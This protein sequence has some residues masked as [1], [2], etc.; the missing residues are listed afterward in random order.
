[1]TEQYTWTDNPTLSGVALCNTDVL[2]EC[3]MHLKYDKSGGSGLELCDIGTALYIDETIGLRRRLNGS[4]MD[5]TSNYQAFLA[6]L[7]EIKTTNPDYFTDEDTWQ[8]EATL[9]VDG[10]VYKFVLNYDSTGTNVVSVRLPKYPDY[11]EVTS[12]N[13]PVVGNGKTLG[14][15]TGSKNFGIME[16]ANQAVNNVFANRGA[17]NV[18][19]GKF[20]PTGWD[21]EIDQAL[22][23]TTDPTKSG[24]QT[25]GGITK[26]KLIYFIQVAT[27]QETENNIVDDIELNNPF[28]FGMSQYYKGEMNNISWLKSNGGFHPK[29]TYPSF[30]DWVYQQLNA[31]QFDPSKITVV[32]N[33]IITDDGIASGLSKEN[34]IKMYCPVEN[35]KHLKIKTTFKYFKKEGATLQPLFWL[36]PN[37]DINGRIMYLS[38]KPNGDLSTALRDKGYVSGSIERFIDGKTYTLEYE[39]DMVTYFKIYIDGVLVISQQTG[40]NIANITNKLNYIVLPAG[41]D[42]NNPTI[43][44]YDLK[45]FSITVDGEEVYSPTKRLDGF[46][47]NTENYDDYDIVINPTDETFR[48]ALKNGM[49]GMFASGVKG[50]GKALVVTDGNGNERNLFQSGNDYIFTNDN[51]AGNLPHVTASYNGNQTTSYALGTNVGLTTDSSKS[52]IVVDTTVPSGHNLYYYVGETVQNANLIDAGRIGEELGNKVSISNTQWATNAC[53]PDYTAGIALTSATLQGFVAPQIGIITGAINWNSST[54]Y[55]KVNGYDVLGGYTESSSAYIRLAKG[56]KLSYD[57]GVVEA[58]IT[59]LYFYPLKGANNV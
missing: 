17:F 43:I 36:Y 38:I 29:A 4:I 45:A 24:I 30:Y 37:A 59:R 3:L 1:M 31:K 16:T 42:T 53:T 22:G 39:T 19:V 55:L 27:G 46:K 6:R 5:I 2:N 51:V 28:A 52:G 12:N 25:S 13:I 9:N 15:T 8:S 49:E 48:L 56:D 41:L 26:L 7:L 18:P 44:E 32:G 23:V 14:F 40:L 11:V 34:L 58:N 57:S 21:G 35:G 54:G 20:T 10:C 33:P 47:R 50:N